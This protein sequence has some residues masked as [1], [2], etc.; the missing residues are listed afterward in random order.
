[1]LVYRRVTSKTIG[2]AKVYSASHDF[3]E[4]KGFWSGYYEVPHGDGDGWW[5]RPR[6]VA[7]RAAEQ[8]PVGTGFGMVCLNRYTYTL[9]IYIIDQNGVDTP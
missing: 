1:M 2:S 9:Y 6:E 5:V 8:W 7:T 4:Y 3:P